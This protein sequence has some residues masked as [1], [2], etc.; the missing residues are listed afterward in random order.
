MSMQC[1]LFKNKHK[2]FC[3]NDP[4]KSNKFIY[5]EYNV[6]AC[7]KLFQVQKKIMLKQ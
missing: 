4:S 5:S 2:K 3:V 6:L 1:I 7:K